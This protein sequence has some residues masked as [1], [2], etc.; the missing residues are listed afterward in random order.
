MLQMPVNTLLGT[1]QEVA[2]LQQAAANLGA[3]DLAGLDGQQ[4]TNWNEAGLGFVLSDV[5]RS[6]LFDLGDLQTRASALVRAVREGNLAGARCLRED[7]VAEFAEGATSQKEQLRAEIAEGFSRVNTESDLDELRA[8]WKKSGMEIERNR[9]GR[10]AM[11]KSLLTSPKSV[12]EGIYRRLI[13]ATF[14]SDPEAEK[15][16]VAKMEDQARKTLEAIQNFLKLEHVTGKKETAQRLLS[17]R[18]ILIAFRNVPWKLEFENQ[19]DPEAVLDTARKYFDEEI[20]KVRQKFAFNRKLLGEVAAE[21]GVEEDVQRIQES[22]FNCFLQWYHLT[23]LKHPYLTGVATAGSAYVG[24]SVIAKLIV[25]GESPVTWEQ[26]GIL[27]A[28]SLYYGWEIPVSLEAL[29][30]DIPVHRH[31]HVGKMRAGAYMFGVSP[32]WTVRHASFLALVHGRPDSA[33][34]IIGSG[35]ATWA[36]TLPPIY[37]I[38]SFI[39]GKIPLRY[40]F[41]SQASVIMAWHTVASLFT[42]LG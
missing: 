38:E 25:G 37:L 39:Q 22:P 35:L 18:Q 32:S 31:K 3:F 36:T 12:R 7:L 28:L 17:K 6:G 24:G 15:Y 1:S 19:P 21:Y 20:Q 2:S 14:D 26:I 42:L 16:T 34:G 11:V 8:V 10:G 9:P 33:L 13:E 41:L 29:E 30:T 40:R 4:S 5:Y 23:N 27:G